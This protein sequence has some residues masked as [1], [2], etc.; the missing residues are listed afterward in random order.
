VNRLPF[1][2]RG[3]EAKVR[4]ELVK[5]LAADF[6]VGVVGMGREE[7][8]VPDN[9]IPMPDVEQ[10]GRQVREWIM[11]AHGHLA[12][13]PELV[14]DREGRPGN[15]HNLFRLRDAQIQGMSWADKGENARRLLRRYLL[16]GI[17]AGEVLAAHH[18]LLSFHP[19]TWEPQNEESRIAQAV[20]DDLL[21]SPRTVR[22][23]LFVWR[24]SRGGANAATGE[25]EV[26][27]FDA[28]DA[29]ARQRHRWVITHWLLHEYAHLVEHPGFTWYR[30]KA[31]EVGS[32]GDHILTEGIATLLNRIWW[33]GVWPATLDPRIRLIIE[34]EYAKLPPETVSAVAGYDS[35]EQAMDLVGVLGIDATQALYIRG[36]TAQL[37]GQLPV[38]PEMAPSAAEAGELAG[39]R[40][41]RQEVPAEMASPLASEIDVALL[42]ALY[43]LADAEPSGQPTASAQAG[44]TATRGVDAAAAAQVRAPRPAAPPGRDIRWNSG[45][46]VPAPVGASPALANG[47]SGQAANSLPPRPSGP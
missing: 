44:P 7:Y 37:T 26:N 24:G 5:Q 9:L 46:G 22:E 39:I 15:L 42:Q 21:I 2:S 8:D 17:A 36:D 6:D 1:A 14:A 23:M 3:F 27:S 33:A 45:S 16:A 43:A 38:I 41:R 35:V 25:I 47:G 18:A 30:K 40:M 28:G 4:K 10:I 29:A 31:P 12:P 19:E 20:I 32:R 13:V 34:G 11:L